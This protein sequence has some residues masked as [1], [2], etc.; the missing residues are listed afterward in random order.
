M[1]FPLSK[2]TNG[3]DDDLQRRLSGGD[4]VALEAKYHAKCLA[5]LYNRATMVKKE[6]RITSITCPMAL[7]LQNLLHILKRN[8]YRMPQ[9]LTEKNIH[10]DELMT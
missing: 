1:K 7:H 4:M 3:F 6:D 9:L 2:Q 5:S 8:V 10:P